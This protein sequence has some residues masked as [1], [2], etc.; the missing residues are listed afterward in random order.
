MD[1]HVAALLAM[2]APVIARRPQAD[3]AIQQ[4]RVHD[5]QRICSQTT[6][7]IAPPCGLA[8]TMEGGHGLRSWRVAHARIVPLA[9]DARQRLGDTP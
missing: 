1:R 9:E 6:R 7:W 5:H 4:G 3:A 8:M 2:T